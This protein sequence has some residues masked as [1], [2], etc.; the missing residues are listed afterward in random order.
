MA[1]TEPGAFFLV[2]QEWETCILSK[3][4]EG[5]LSNQKALPSSLEP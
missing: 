1:T 3:G 4:G 2:C 5:C